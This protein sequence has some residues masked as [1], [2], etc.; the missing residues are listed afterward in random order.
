M[1]YSVHCRR[2]AYRFKVIPK[3]I[4]QRAPI[5]YEGRWL[6]K[7]YDTGISSEA[8]WFVRFNNQS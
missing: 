4:P 1:I 2:Y 5:W 7:S 3:L 8:L 6:V